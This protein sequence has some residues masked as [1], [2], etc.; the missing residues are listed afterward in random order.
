MDRGTYK[1][2]VGLQLLGLAFLL[3]GMWPVAMVI[4]VVGH[5]FQVKRTVRDDPPPSSAPTPKPCPRRMES[6]EYLDSETPVYYQEAYEEVYQEPVAT[7]PKAK[8]K[9]AKAKAKPKTW[10]PRKGKYRTVSETLREDDGSYSKWE[11][12]AYV[13]RG[14]QGTPVVCDYDEHGVPTDNGMEVS[15]D[16]WLA[17]VCSD[18]MGMRGTA[19][20]LA[21]VVKGNNDCLVK[22]L[23]VNDIE[24]NGRP[25]TVKQMAQDGKLLEIA[26]ALRQSYV[27]EVG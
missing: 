21:H 9:K 4:F 2:W 13:I 16:G 8:R 7:K 25:A 26:E 14:P 23:Q 3:C 10:K 6:D 12:N 15:A 18:E 11:P 17:D 22:A 19:V 5:I 27:E 1:K 24:F 20:V